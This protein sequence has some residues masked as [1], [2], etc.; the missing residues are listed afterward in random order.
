MAPL[1][2][3]TSPVVNVMINA[4]CTFALNWFITNTPEAIA[5]KQINEMKAGVLVEDYKRQQA[6]QTDLATQLDSIGPLHLTFHDRACLATI[7]DMM[8]SQKNR[9]SIGGKAVEIIME[10]GGDLSTLEP[11]HADFRTR[12]FRH[13]SDVSDEEAQKTWAKVLAGELQKPGSYSLRTLDILRNITREEADAIRFLKA[14]TF[15]GEL[16]QRIVLTSSKENQEFLRNLKIAS[17]ANLCPIPA[18]TSIY[19]NKRFTFPEVPISI[20]AGALILKF[21][22]QRP[23]DL[24]CVPCSA[25]LRE[26]WQLAGEVLPA[27][28]FVSWMALNLRHLGAKVTVNAPYIDDN[29]TFNQHEHP[30]LFVGVGDARVVF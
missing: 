11:P 14:Y 13:A 24:E 27:V 8:Q 10:N 20:L 12:F 25:S 30:M 23:L 5:R 16:P 4:F 3:L 9:E 7:N 1:S 26:L 2:E 22:E 28:Q 17:L 19:E 29:L 6:Q 15:E 21:E 18:Q